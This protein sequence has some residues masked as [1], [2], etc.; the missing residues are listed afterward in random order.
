M[1]Y[2]LTTWNTHP[3]FLDPVDGY[4]PAFSIILVGNQIADSARIVALSLQLGRSV[5]N[6]ELCVGGP[7]LR[8]RCCPESSWVP[9]PRSERDLECTWSDLAPVMVIWSMICSARAVKAKQK[10]SD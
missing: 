6:S 9:E 7:L 3:R 10:S 1:V 5:Q 2:L 8:M 4:R